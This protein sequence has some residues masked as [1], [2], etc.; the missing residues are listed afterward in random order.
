MRRMIRALLWLIKGTL[1]AVALAAMALSF[2]SFWQ[3]G[4]IKVSRFTLAPDKVQERSI[5][6]NYEDGRIIVADKHRLLTGEFIDYGRRN[7][8]SNGIGW[9]W[10]GG[11]ITSEFAPSLLDHSFGP[12]RWSSL[13]GKAPHDAGSVRQVSIPCWFVALFAGAWPLI[14][15]VLW[16]RRRRQ[17]RLIRLRGCCAICGYDLRATPEPGGE[18]LTRCPECGA[19][20][21]AANPAV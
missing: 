19:A 20:C 16:S 14:S 6:L 9:Q 8:E 11:F 1:L 7:A 10:K 5:F 4:W 12:F 13:V 3:W 18:L 2:S 17:R 15:L 21:K